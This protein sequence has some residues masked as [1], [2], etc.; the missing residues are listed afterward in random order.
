MQMGVVGCIMSK[1]ENTLYCRNSIPFLW[2][3]IK[4][5]TYLKSNLKWQYRVRHGCSILLSV[6]V[7]VDIVLKEHFL[8]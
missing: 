7:S 3:V 6:T 2:H 4:C 5:L 1:R 8:Y